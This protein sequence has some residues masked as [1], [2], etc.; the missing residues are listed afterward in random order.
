LIVVMA[1][2]LMPARKG[3]AS[4]TSLGFIFGT[5]AIGTLVIGALSD[6]LTLPTTFQIV[7]IVTFIAGIVAL[8]LPS[9]RRTSVPQEQAELI[10]ASVEVT[11]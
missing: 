3:L 9:E 6:R 4:G 2:K 5:G 10:E 1:Q 7:G 11:V 8:G